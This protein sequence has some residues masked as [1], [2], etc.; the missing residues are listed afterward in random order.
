MKQQMNLIAVLLLGLGLAGS[1][2]VQAEE[3]LEGLRT[4]IEE[5]KKGQSE[6]RKQL[7][8]ILKLVTP[9]KRETVSDINV[10]LDVRDDPAK[11]SADAEITLVEFTDYQC[12][13]CARHVKSVK[14]Q[15]IKDYVDSGKVRYVLRDF[16]LSFHKDAK[17]AAM[18]AHC[19]AEQGKYWEMHD[20][21]FANQKALG[22]D[23]L[24]EYAGGLELDVAAFDECMGSERYASKVDNSMK[25]GTKATVR[26]TPSFVVGKVGED[27]KVKGSKIIRGA[28]GYTVFKETLDDMLKGD[29]QPKA[30]A[31][32]SKN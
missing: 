18:A 23:K 20:V 2:S 5:L 8:E 30:E 27:G 31:D 3:N 22:K 6:M 9:K 1:V 11:G 25:D 24:S 26:G 12:P 15:F 29:E 16:P 19:A 14:P 28:V 13:F 21:L 10:V 7:G 32:P 4:D 17:N